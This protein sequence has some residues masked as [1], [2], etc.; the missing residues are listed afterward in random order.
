MYLDTAIVL[1]ALQTYPA[2]SE[3]IILRCYEAS[4]FIHT[5]QQ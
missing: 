4:T 1:S 3:A 5:V 2:A